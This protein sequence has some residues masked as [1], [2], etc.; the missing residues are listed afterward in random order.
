M[1]PNISHLSQSWQG[2]L[3]MFPMWTDGLLS[4]RVSSFLQSVCKSPSLCGLGVTS[5]SSPGFWVVQPLQ[6]HNGGTKTPRNRV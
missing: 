4:Y 1:T 3:Q 2:F 6:T 5:Y